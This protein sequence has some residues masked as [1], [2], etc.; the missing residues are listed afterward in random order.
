M[1]ANT[2]P[3]LQFSLPP[4][5]LHEIVQEARRRAAELLDATPAVRLLGEGSFFDFLDDVLQAHDDLPE[6]GTALDD[7]ALQY[8]YVSRSRV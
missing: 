3:P 5:P 6:L 8:G 4:S 1:V 7:V 2:L